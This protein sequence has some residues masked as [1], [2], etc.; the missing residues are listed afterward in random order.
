MRRWGRILLG[1]VALGIVGALAFFLWPA[2]LEAVQA[3]AGQPTGPALVERGRYLATAGDCVACHS[4]P[5]GKP[6]AGGLA[7]KLP[8][9]TIYSSNITPDRQHG[10]GGWSD[11]QFVRAMRHGIDDQGH[12]LYPAFPYTAY[13]NMSTDDLLAIRAYLQTLAPVSAAVEPNRLSFPF[14]Q[15]YL[16]RAWKLF[17]GPQHPLERDASRSPEWN[18]GAYLVEG[19]GHCAE[20][21]TP[22]NFL[23]GLNRSRNYAGAV[24]QGWKAYNITSDPEV[25]IGSWSVEEIAAYLGTGHAPGRG[26]ASGSMAEAVSLSLRHLTPQDLRAMAVYLHSLPPQPGEPGGKVDANP[27]LMRASTP[28]AP[29]LAETRGDPRGLRLYEGACASCH[30]WNGEG[31][32]TPYG[33]LRGAQTVNDPEATNLVQVIL[34]GTQ[35]QTAEGPLHMPAFGHAFTDAEVAALANYVLAHF[36]NKQ[37][38]V[39]PARVAKARTAG[40]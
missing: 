25:G 10:I 27:P 39:T 30:G 22:R 8:F 18:R 28:F 21:H 20:C 9:G 6:Y 19:P 40:E 26:A 14:N 17:N 36:G 29:A 37:P 13:A 1:L 16:M 12:E 3:S 33:A 24:T 11:A 38:S 32:Q 34:H 23:Y 5:G 7:F 35:I 15:R 4:V 2:R 31:L